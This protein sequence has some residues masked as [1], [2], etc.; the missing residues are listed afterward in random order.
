[1]E[2]KNWLEI[3]STIKTI[4][5]DFP[6]RRLCAKWLGLYPTSL[7]YSSTFLV[8]TS[9]ILFSLALP[10]RIK[11]TVVMDIPKDYAISLMDIFF[12]AFNL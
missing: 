7:I 6:S 8:R 4:T 2:A 10:F 3:S 11:E 12:F 9:L 5:L 1:M